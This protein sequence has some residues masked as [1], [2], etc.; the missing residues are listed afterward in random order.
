MVEL[1]R[2]NSMLP[3]KRSGTVF[4]P[5]NCVA[6]ISRKSD[7]GFKTFLR[8]SG[9]SFLIGLTNLIGVESLD[10][11]AE[12]CGDGYAFSLPVSTVRDCLP[13]PDKFS[14]FQLKALSQIAERAFFDT[15]C[16]GMHTGMHRLARV[17]L[18]AADAFGEGRAITITQLE[19]SEILM[20]RRETVSQLLNEWTA[21]GLVSLR[22]GCVTIENKSELVTHACSCYPVIKQFERAELAGWREI[23]WILPSVSKYA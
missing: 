5:I 20:L 23:P 7:D 22:R 13:P 8:F 3:D 1:K 11:I 21:R 17:L 18:E 15:R 6:K 9:P 19:L 16:L 2:G 4:F 12:V 10:L 14:A